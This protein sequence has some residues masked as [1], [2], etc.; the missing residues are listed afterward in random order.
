[1]EEIKCPNCGAPAQNHKNCEFCGSLLVRFS[2]KNIDLTQTSYL[3]N[4]GVLPGLVKQLQK[5]LELQQKGEGWV[6]TY[7][8]K[9]N[10]DGSLYSLC[11]IIS[12]NKITNRDGDLFFPNADNHSIAVAFSFFDYSGHGGGDHFRKNRFE[13]LASFPLFDSHVSHSNSIR[14]S[15]NDNDWEENY[16]EY[17]ID[18]GRDAEGAAR[19]ISE[20]VEK[21]YYWPINKSPIYKTVT[22]K[23]YKNKQIAKWIW[24]ALAALG[25]LL[26]MIL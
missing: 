14:S 24:I 4:D 3:N 11:H 17:A 13:Q 8:S 25:F 1:M 18:F 19:L 2:S 12:S 15:S 26:W 21:V 5:N 16:Y 10:S 6:H 7:I 23:E 20:I 22:E 9:K